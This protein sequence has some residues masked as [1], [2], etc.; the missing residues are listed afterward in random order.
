MIFIPI[1]KLIEKTHGPFRLATIACRRAA[2]LVEGAR[3]LIDYHEDKLATIALEE[4]LA[5]KVSELRDED[6]DKNKK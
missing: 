5:G 1:E 2:E 4:I 3:P 6:S